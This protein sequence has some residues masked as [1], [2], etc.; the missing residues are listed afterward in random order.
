[1]L[2]LMLLA[3]RVDHEGVGSPPSHSSC[4]SPLSVTRHVTP[5]A[6]VWG[7]ILGTGGT[8]EDE[9][10]PETTHQQPYKGH[11]VQQVKYLAC[12]AA[13]ITS[14][15]HYIDKQYVERLLGPHH[16]SHFQERDWKE[17]S[18]QVDTKIKLGLLEKFYDEGWLNNLTKVQWDSLNI[19]LVYCPE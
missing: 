5:G 2:L 15:M 11:L 10:N 3:C 4:P 12:K 1:M 18:A 17:Q 19:K 13:W 9:S 14:L 16:G 6:P 8:S 7:V